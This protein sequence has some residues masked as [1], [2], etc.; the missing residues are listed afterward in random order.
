[1]SSTTGSAFP[2]VEI[3]G[4]A[5]ERGRQYGQQAGERIAAGLDL[6]REVFATRGVDWELALTLAAEFAPR[7]R[8]YDAE[9]YAEMEGI[10]DGSDHSL[11]GVVILNARTE[12]LFWQDR[13]SPVTQHGIQEDCS[14]VLALPCVTR[15]GRLLH[16]QNW[17][18][19]P[20]CADTSVVVKIHAE[21]G[22]DILTFVEA[23]QLARH[24][25]NSAGIALT[26]NGLQCELDGGHIGVPN[27]LIRRRILQSK[28]LAEALDTVLGANITYSHALTLSH[29]DGEAFCIETTPTSRFWLEPEDGVLVHAN[30]FKAPAALARHTDVGL[31]RCP[32]SLYRDGRLRKHLMSACPAVDVECIR[33]ALADDWGS[34]DAVL[35]S[36]KLREGGTVSAT[37]ASEIMEPET[38]R[39]WLAPRP[40]EGIEYT[41]YRL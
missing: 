19:N 39:M 38:G 11:E 22:P 35:R 20:A 1:M 29:K 40:Y 2:L 36:P 31:Q 10:A 15:E 25:M 27:P 30:H 37:V 6:Y 12:L 13:H 32:E 41:Q 26:V 34:P 21:N 28:S 18:W 33:Q 17:D 4:P 16:A 9:M 7:M 14:S 3:G 23:G 24:G 8:A 5:F